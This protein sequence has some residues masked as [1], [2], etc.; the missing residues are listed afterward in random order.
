MHDRFLKLDPLLVQI[1]HRLDPGT[2]L[3]QQAQLSYCVDDLTIQLKSQVLAHQLPPETYRQVVEGTAEDHRFATWWDHFKATYRSRWWM[4]WRTWP[5]YYTRVQV[6]YRH[7]AEVVVRGHWSF[8][9]ARIA[10][11]PE[12]LGAPVYVAIT[13]PRT[14]FTRRPL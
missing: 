9:D 7:T 1:R 6:P 8:P 2:Y 11:Y 3:S 10:A 12:E 14:T 5:I 13:E 4:R